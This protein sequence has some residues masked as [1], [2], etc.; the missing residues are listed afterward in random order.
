MRSL[1]NRLHALEAGWTASNWAPVLNRLSNPELD[2]LEAI[3]IR[4]EDGSPSD[5]PVESD[6]ALIAKLQD[7]KMKKGG[8]RPCA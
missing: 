3:V 1:R 7:L 5:R 4:L 8:A 6:L 2:Q